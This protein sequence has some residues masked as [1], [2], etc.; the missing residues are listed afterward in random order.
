VYSA[1]AV[2]GMRETS[3][4]GIELQRLVEVDARVESLHGLVGAD[5]G[6]ALHSEFGTLLVQSV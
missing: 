6:G 3:G 4:R 1:R 2:E 5:E